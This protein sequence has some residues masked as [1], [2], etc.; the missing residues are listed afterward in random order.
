M[1]TDASIS[2]VTGI[3]SSAPFGNSKLPRHDADD[4]DR[5]VLE[6]ELTT[7]DLRV[8]AEQAA[9]ALK[10]RYASAFLYRATSLDQ[11]RSASGLL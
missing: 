9:H 11:A 7:H 4:S 5:F 10:R 1:P 3:Q 6:G 2:G 8:A